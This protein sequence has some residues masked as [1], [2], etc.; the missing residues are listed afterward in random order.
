MKRIQ[1]RGFSLVEMV[2]TIVILSILAF[3]VAYILIEGFKVWMENKSLVELRMDGRFVFS[4][5]ASEF[6]LAEEVLFMPSNTGEISFCADIDGD[7]VLEQIIYKR[8]ESVATRLV[9]SEDGASQPICESLSYIT[10]SWDNNRR[11]LNVNM[12]LSKQGD[13]IKLETEITPRCLPLNI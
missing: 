13:E 10:F 6:R 11:L 7:G 12:G 9:R 1:R 5:F 4:R 2:T 3:S 8:D